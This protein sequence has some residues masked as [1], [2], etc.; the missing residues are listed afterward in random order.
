MGSLFSCEQGAAC[1]PNAKHAR[2]SGI[3][4]GGNNYGR[5]ALSTDV[6]GGG[7]V[8][9]ADLINREL[10]KIDPERSRDSRCTVL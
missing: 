3:D 5:L 6:S 1:S 7:S 4:I 10:F 9:A 2:I 8:Q